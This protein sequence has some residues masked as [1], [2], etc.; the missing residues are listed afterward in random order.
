MSDNW[1]VRGTRDPQLVR[2]DWTEA[3]AA[4]IDG[5]RAR[6]I[7]NVLTDDGHL[8]EIWRDEWADE[9]AA[10][11]RHVFQRVLAP[12]SIGD[13]HA[14]ESTTDHLFCGTGQISLALFD[15][16]QDSP[17]HGDVATFRIGAPRPAVVTIP[18][19][20]WHAVRCTSATPGVLVIAVDEP[21]D[22]ERP[23]HRR[24]PAG[25]PAI[26]HTP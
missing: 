3:D 18:P 8:T 11:I 1:S 6:V 14:H 22:Y 21:Y 7:T 25:T 10:P 26:P 9:G 15:G 17:T 12:G 19:G 23:D 2:S 4:S 16:R 20:V 13:W 5:V 24:L